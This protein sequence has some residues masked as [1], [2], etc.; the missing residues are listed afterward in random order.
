MRPVR[1]RWTP[2]QNG[3]LKCNIDGSYVDS[4][5]PSTAGWVIRDSNGYY[6]VAGQ[7]KGNKVHI[8][9]SAILLVYIAMQFCSSKGY[10]KII[11]EGDNKKIIDIL[12]KERLHFDVHNWIREMI[13]CFI[14]MLYFANAYNSLYED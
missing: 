6:L 8:M 12:T 10:K 14:F 2:P 9:L 3:W 11:F 7:A 1:K 4:F 13:L 5:T